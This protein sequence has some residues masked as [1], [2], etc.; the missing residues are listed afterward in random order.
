MAHEQD[1]KR[2]A[3]KRYVFDQQALPTISIHIDVPEGTVRRWKA[4]AKEAGDD[5]DMAKSANLMSGEGLEAVIVGVL[6]D[7]VVQHQATIDDLKADNSLT[8]LERSKILASLAYS[9]NQTVVAAGRVA[10]KISELGVANDV[11]KRFGDFVLSAHPH[12]APA[13]LEVL[14]SF[15]THLGEIY[16]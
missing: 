4:L 11:L 10:P 3:R 13:L 6:Q 1:K 7:Y 16:K 14:E 2:D 12:V 8:A 5:W 9:F 15:G